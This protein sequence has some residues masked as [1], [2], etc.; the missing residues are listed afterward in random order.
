MF[1]D[2][3]RRLEDALNRASSPAEGRE[4][5]AQI[6]TL[7][8]ADGVLIQPYWRSLYRH[9]REGVHGAEQNPT[10]DHHPYKGWVD[11]NA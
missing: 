8:R 9:T 2:L 6:E 3:R 1:D 11:S 7:M 10:I 5:L 4:V